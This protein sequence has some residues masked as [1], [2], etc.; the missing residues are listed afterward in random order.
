MSLH[1]SINSA[2]RS[3]IDGVIELIEQCSAA[4]AEAPG[5]GKEANGKADN[6]E[7]TCNKRLGHCSI[8]IGK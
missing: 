2:L 7:G 1:L 6:A 5:S 8:P 3:V 4:N